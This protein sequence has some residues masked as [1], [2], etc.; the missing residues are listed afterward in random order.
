[1]A[2]RESVKRALED[3]RKEQSAK[4]SPEIQQ[5]S[6]RRYNS[7]GE[8]LWNGK[9]AKEFTPEDVAAFMSETEAVLNSYE[10]TVYG[11]ILAVKREPSVELEPAD[12]FEK[13]WSGMNEVIREEEPVQNSISNNRE[14]SISYS[15]NILLGDDEDSARNQAYDIIHQASMA[16]SQDMSLFTQ[17]MDNVGR[18]G[19]NSYSVNN[20]LLVTV[21]GVDT[22][23]LKSEERW[24]EQNCHVLPGSKPV[25]VLEPAGAYKERTGQ[26]TNYYYPKRLYPASSVKNAEGKIPELKGS[27]KA[28]ELKLLIDSSP[29]KI[30][31][32]SKMPEGV[33]AR[34]C[35]EDNIIYLREGVK[36]IDR[37]Y[38]SLSKEIVHANAFAESNEKYLRSNQELEA[39][40]VSYIL[41]RNS[42]LNVK[43]MGY[44]F[45][46]V[47][48]GIDNLGVNDDERSS[49]MKDILNVVK[50]DAVKIM[51]DM[52]KIKTPET[53]KD[54][55]KEIETTKPELNKATTKS[56]IENK[57]N[58]V[59]K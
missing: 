31:I 39:G 27:D 1:M 2:E 48:S 26:Q 30:C 45:N 46:I 10:G 14:I 59:K 15:E 20:F 6:P 21:Q 28:R 51:Q 3:I 8:R 23:L 43:Q 32:A 29:A 16:V 12:L 11:D 54:K 4:Q 56:V 38:R 22:D 9:T 25:I 5:R 35:P 17:Y 18:L 19:A 47:K 57:K 52:G 40:L 24:H 50:K 49:L 33:D 42:G 36:S 44:D 34:F 41:C 37:I 55:S 13:S 58:S 7:A 53:H